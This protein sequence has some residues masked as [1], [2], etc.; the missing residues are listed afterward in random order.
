MALRRIKKEMQ[1]LELDLGPN[2]SAWL[3]DMD[4]FFEWK[5]KII[6]PTNTP[7][8]GG[9]FLLNIE[10]PGDYPFKAPKIIFK[11]KIYHRNILDKGMIGLFIFYPHDS[12]WSPSMTI[13]KCL[14]D[15]RS[16]LVCPPDLICPIN[17]PLANIY[18]TDRTLYDLM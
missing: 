14:L 13:S 9:T 7:Y 17:Y 12:D 1:S 4:D 15:I 5:A 16:M 10:L 11:T 2:I 6:G 3:D 8:E 18:M